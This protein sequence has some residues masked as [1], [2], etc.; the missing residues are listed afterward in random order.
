MKDPDDFPVRDEAPRNIK[1]LDCGTMM[2]R[3]ERDTKYDGSHGFDFCC[4]QCGSTRLEE[5]LLRAA[6]LD[7]ARVFG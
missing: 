1:C 6:L 3:S 4:C 7:I 2:A 5:D